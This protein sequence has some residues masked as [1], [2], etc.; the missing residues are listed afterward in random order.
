M[1]E[2]AQLT[3]AII[4]CTELKKIQDIVRDALDR[5]AKPMEIVDAVTKGLDRVG[6]LYE[7]GEYFLMELT[8]AGSTASDIMAMIKPVLESS[9]IPVRGKVV[10]GTVLG[11]FHNIG[12]DIVIAMLESAGFDVINLGVD[13]STERFLSA[14][15]ETKP[16]VL[17]MSG[18]LTIVVD[19]MKKVIDALK[20]DGLR[21]AVKVMIGGRAVS[22]KFANEIGADGFG[23]TAVDAVRLVKKWVEGK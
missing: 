17:A 1:K 18:L 19:E 13:V 3:K 22:Y 20:R 16:H 14:V 4:E 10:I 8:I 23:V 21:D 6:D 15:K 7:R 9:A 11:D 2:L 5:G 12:K